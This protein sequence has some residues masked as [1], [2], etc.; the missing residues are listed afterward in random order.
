M[1]A[2]EDC[3]SFH[4]TQLL[5]D[6]MAGLM[7]ST[8]TFECSGPLGPS[9]KQSGPSFVD[10]ASTTFA[11]GNYGNTDF[12][13]GGLKQQ[14]ACSVGG[15]QVI[16]WTGAIAAPCSDL[17][18]DYARVQPKGI[19]TPCCNSDGC[20]PPATKYSCD[21]SRALQLC[22]LDGSAAQ[23]VD[24]ATNTI[25]SRN[26]SA[27][28]VLSPS[29]P[30]DC[31]SFHDT[32]LLSDTMAGLMN[33]T[34]TFEC[35]GPLGPSKKQSGPSFVDCASTTFAAGN[36][37]N[38]D[39]CIGG[40]KQQHACSVGGCQVIDWTGAIAA[41]CSDLIIDYARVQPKGIATPCCNSDGC[42]PPATKYSCDASRA[43]Q[44]CVL[45]GSAVQCVDPVTNAICSRNYSTA[46]VLPPGSSTS[47]SPTQQTASSPGSSNAVT[48]FSG[49]SG[50]SST[51]I[52]A[53]VTSLVGAV[54]AVLTHRRRCV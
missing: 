2:S 50:L 29:S 24:P 34:F 44:L 5:S 51:D 7:N 37:G 18:I 27:A 52:I 38:T 8:F 32:Q 22:V 20:T 23:C 21:A 3:G 4:D 49:H 41:P 36:Y 19:A 16:D 46:V 53:I 1:S 33:S 25:C 9:K 26:Y 48:S 43:L 30:E 12:C 42:T 54:A 13:I 40:L 14:H 35:S 10:C 31:G 47:G 45:D 15:C 17:I 28:A 39:F 6:T 11:A